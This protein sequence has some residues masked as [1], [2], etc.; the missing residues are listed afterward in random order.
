[1]GPFEPLKGS[2]FEGEILVI[3]FIFIVLNFNK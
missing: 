3:I 1:M 2:K